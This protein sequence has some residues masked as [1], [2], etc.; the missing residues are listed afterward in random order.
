MCW[1]SVDDASII[2]YI[3]ACVFFCFFFS[4]RRRHTRSLC[5]WS[6]DVCSSDLRGRRRVFPRKIG[7]AR[8]SCDIHVVLII[9]RH[10]G[11]NIY[12]AAANIR[13]E[14]QVP[15]GNVQFG[16]KRIVISSAISRSEERRVGKGIIY[17]WYV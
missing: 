15:T 17:M 3:D 4:S 1:P 14:H 8:A 11:G 13:R 9:D 16:Y 7:G 2:L 5:D 12:V 6:S 10:A